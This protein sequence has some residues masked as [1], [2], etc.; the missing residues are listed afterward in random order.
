MT[1]WMWSKRPNRRQGIGVISNTFLHYK[2]PLLLII[3][4]L[5][6]LIFL[7]PIRVLIASDCKTGQYLKSWPIKVGKDFHVEYTHSVELTPVIEI[8]GI[9]NRETIL[10]KETYFYSYGA[11]LPATSAHDFEISQEGLRIYNIDQHMEDI[12]YRT[13]AVRAHHKININGRTYPFLDFSKPRTGVRFS[14]GDL[15]L[16][17]YMAREV[18]Q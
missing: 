7:M 3:A 17:S 14:L 15:S 4:G 18:L 5:I 10:L 1:R 11:G 16:L 13:G 8:Y 12:V 9:Y 2:K 6:V